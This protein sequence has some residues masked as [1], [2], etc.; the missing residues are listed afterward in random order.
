MAVLATPAAGP[1]PQCCDAPVAPTL[2]TSVSCIDQHVLAAPL[3]T[4]NNQPV[5]SRMRAVNVRGGS[6]ATIEWTMQDQSGNPV[7]LSPC[8]EAC[9][10]DESDSS[11]DSDSSSASEV[12][13]TEAFEVKF[14]IREHLSVGC[15]PSPEQ[16]QYIAEVV[17]AA[18]GTVRV[19]LPRGATS[20]PGVY[21]AE[22]AVVGT[23]TEGCEYVHFSNI[24]YVYID[25]AMWSASSGLGQGPPSLAEIRLHLRDSGGQEN[26]LL[27]NLKFDDA[28][29]ALAI[30][31]PVQYWNE[32]P[33]PLNNA[34]T[35]QNFP[36]RFHWLEGICAN[37]FWM[38]AEQYRANNLQYSA[39]GVSV[40]DQD[41]EPQYEKAAERRWANFKEFVRRKKAS[42]NLEGA[43]GGIGSSYNQ[44]YSGY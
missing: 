14:R 16:T 1:L 5:L 25:R 40:N 10:V 41:K 31:R 19:T 17:D 37:L 38:V 30:A 34:L 6:Q 21:F 28:E 39:A 33:P 2:L 44:S 15:Q 12:V 27:D 32:I 18:E 36:F 13:C 29:I 23:D 4:V 3:S 35:T 8:V 42:I 9:D 43:Y 22:F 7:D 20:V 11:G 26:F 24:F